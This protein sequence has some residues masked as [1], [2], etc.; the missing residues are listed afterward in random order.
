MLPVTT[1]SYPTSW[2]KVY[3]LKVGYIF[4]QS[5]YSDV[6]S[7]G[8][9]GIYVDLLSIIELRK[10]VS[11]CRVEPPECLCSRSCVVGA[12]LFDHC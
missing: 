9:L 6:E 5:L 4:E 12:H 10:R 7:D 3:E 11:Y 2:C 8:T 1:K